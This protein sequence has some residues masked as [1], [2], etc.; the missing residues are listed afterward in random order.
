MEA[1]KNLMI[2]C[3]LCDTRHMNEEDYTD[4]EHIMINGDCLVVNSRSKS[5][6]NRLPHDV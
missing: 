1:K 2:N 3:D 5:I 6:L 4:F